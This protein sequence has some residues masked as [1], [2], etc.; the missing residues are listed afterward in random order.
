MSSNTPQP[1]NTTSSPPSELQIENLKISSQ[2]SSLRANAPTATTTAQTILA[3]TKQVSLL[4]TSLT[5][6]Q[7]QISTQD[8]LLVKFRKG[9]L[10]AEHRAIAAEKQTQAEMQK[11]AEVM[12]RVRRSVVRMEKRWEE[13]EKGFDGQ[14]AVL[15]ESWM[16]EANENA[17]LRKKVE[18]Y[19]KKFGMLDEE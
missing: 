1:E 11:A 2:S 15:V 12:E 9:K 8:S 18:M 16:E 4:S 7:D 6:L 10:A 3:L 5:R 14:T 17:R 19:E 13:K